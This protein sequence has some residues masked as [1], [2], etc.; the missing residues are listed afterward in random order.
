VFASAQR[1]WV[2]SASNYSR[3]CEWTNSSATMTLPVYSSGFAQVAE[4]SEHLLAKTFHFAA[5]RQIAFDRQRMDT[6]RFDFAG[7]GVETARPP[8]TAILD[9]AR[10]Q[11]D[12][13]AF[14]GKLQRGALADAAARPSNQCDLTFEFHLASGAPANGDTQIRKP[15]RAPP[16]RAQ[17]SLPP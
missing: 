16:G 8:A 13:G 10:G 3:W 2:V 9:R 12:V 6:E 4:A 17:P 15:L 7:S 14:G 11:H 1:R 5:D